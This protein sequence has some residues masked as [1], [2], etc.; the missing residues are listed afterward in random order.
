[1]CSC[2]LLLFASAL[3]RASRLEGWYDD[4]DSKALIVLTGWALADWLRSGFVWCLLLSYEYGL[5]DGM[6]KFISLFWE[7]DIAAVTIFVLSASCSI[8]VL[9]HPQYGYWPWLGAI[10]ATVSMLIG[11]HLVLGRV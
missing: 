2:L 7:I 9:A 5:S 4:G 11:V 3:W 10:A 6:F 1:M 8:R